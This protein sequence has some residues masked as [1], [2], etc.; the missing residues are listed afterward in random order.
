VPEG[1]RDEHGQGKGRVRLAFLQRKKFLSGG[2]VH[3]TAY[4]GIV[5]P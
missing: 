3:K 4:P 2:K 5:Y 1:M